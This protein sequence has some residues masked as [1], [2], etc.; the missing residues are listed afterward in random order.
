MSLG[1][2]MEQQDCWPSPRSAC[3]YDGL[4]G[5]DLYSLKVIEHVT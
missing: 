5:I 4:A 2:A 1:K 3:K